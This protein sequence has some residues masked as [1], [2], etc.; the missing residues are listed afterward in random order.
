[1]DNQTTKDV[2][3]NLL[4]ENQG[5]LFKICNVYCI[6]KSDIQDLA[7]EMVYQ[8]WKSYGTYNPSYKFTTWMYRIALNTAI[9]FY[10]KEKKM[11][12]TIPLEQDHIEIQQQTEPDNPTGHHIILLRQFIN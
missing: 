5:I 2:F 6:K 9:T 1:M 3:S 10:R 4:K 11:G 7:Q 8:L 12:F